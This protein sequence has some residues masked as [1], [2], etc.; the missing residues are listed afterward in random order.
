MDGWPR[1]LHTTFADIFRNSFAHDVCTDRIMQ[2]RL[3]SVESG[4]TV[5]PCH[6]AMPSD[7][8]LLFPPALLGAWKVE[9]ADRLGL[10][11]SP[12]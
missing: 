10:T 4:A 7:L 6:R 3:L 1:L 12:D 2:C 9:P 5:P 8:Q 11:L